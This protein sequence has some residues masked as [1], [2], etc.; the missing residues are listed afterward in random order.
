MRYENMSYE[1]IGLYLQKRLKEICDS[2]DEVIAADSN[3]KLSAL[4]KAKFTLI[5]KLLA[6]ADALTILTSIAAN[7]PKLKKDGTEA[8][9]L[10]YTLCNEFLEDLPKNLEE[11]LETK[12]SS[13]TPSSSSTPTQSGSSTEYENK[14]IIP[15]S[16]LPVAMPDASSLVGLVSSLE[17]RMNKR[18][19]LIMAT[20]SQLTVE[21][22]QM[23]MLLDVA[24]DYINEVQSSAPDVHKAASQRV[25]SKYAG[26]D[27]EQSAVVLFGS[28]NSQATTASTSADNSQGKIL[29][30]SKPKRNI[31]AESQKKLDNFMDKALSSTVS[32]AYKGIRFVENKDTYLAIS[33]QK[34]AFKKRV[35][36][37]KSLLGQ[38]KD[39]PIESEYEILLKPYLL[40]LFIRK[41]DVST[42]TIKQEIAQFL[43]KHEIT[44]DGIIENIFDKV[45][46]DVEVLDIVKNHI[47]PSSAEKDVCLRDVKC[48]TYLE[49]KAYLLI[50][51]ELAKTEY[52]PMLE[53]KTALAILGELARHLE[54]IHKFAGLE[55]D[56]S[57][58][59]TE[60][61]E[62]LINEHVEKIIDAIKQTETRVIE[63]G[64]QKVA[65]GV[66]KHN[67]ELLKKMFSGEAEL[68]NQ[69][70]LELIKQ[71]KL[72]YLIR[73]SQITSFDYLLEKWYRA[74]EVFL[75]E[76]Q[77]QINQKLKQFKNGVSDQA[78]SSSTSSSALPNHSLFF[79]S[80]STTASELSESQKISFKPR[81]ALKNE[82]KLK[83]M[84]ADEMPKGLKL[85]RAHDQGDCFFDSLAQSINQINKT[86][87]NT[88]KY[89]RRLCHD[90]YIENK[91]L[92]DSWNATDFA[93][94]DHQKDEY[95]FVQYTAD[96][97]EE[98]FHGRTPIWGRP[99]I[100]G[101]ILCHQL[102]LQAILI[103]EISEH[104]ANKKPVLSFHLATTDGYKSIGE[105]DAH[106]WLENCKIPAL[107]VEQKS[108]HFVPLLSVDEL[109]I[110]SEQSISSI[111]ELDDINEFLEGGSTSSNSL[112]R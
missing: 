8:D 110:V 19:E 47:K 53:D 90:F 42:N 84:L 18:D 1:E 86:T 72:Y 7:F 17:E 52:G 15:A 70:I 6:D 13:H 27:G 75:N 92:V 49:A 25:L 39:S 20:L 78:S 64:D 108:L 111:Q 82:Q 58:G 107:V 22:K 89:L 46:D 105:E 4:N 100:E 102:K 85:G 30:K 80:A 29:D 43:N 93:G 26:Y 79:G 14:A 71:I 76:R 81:K 16:M 32:R 74:N 40:C 77:S 103:I 37:I 112:N 96:E 99:N 63:F 24:S 69:K 104:P 68:D 33:G 98:N 57:K 109:N 2:V 83:A 60:N 106:V 62:K 54:N 61:T 21:R 88:S 11:L 94:I 41:Y 10:L 59:N 97:C 56:I 5:K 38:L 34:E 95:Y 35:E 55:I 36:I 51:S 50:Y 101:R 31:T 12:K 9:E 3:L 28:A 91:E 73:V 44:V 87:I 23:H 67:Y 65:I 48:L 66:L 45:G